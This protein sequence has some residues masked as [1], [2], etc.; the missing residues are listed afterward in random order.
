MKKPKTLLDKVH[1]HLDLN[2][3]MLG[4]LFIAM[5]ELMIK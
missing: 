1:A 4:L 2:I 5:F 3:I